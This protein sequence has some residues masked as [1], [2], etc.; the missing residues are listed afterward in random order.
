V[1]RRLGRLTSLGLHVH[2][3]DQ[4]PFW[5]ATMA[6]VP[7]GVTAEVGRD[8]AVRRSVSDDHVSY[9]VDWARAPDYGSGRR[10]EPVGAERGHPRDAA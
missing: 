2:Y 6:L 5:T 1:G 4:P 10:P 9:I 3:G 8:V 7:R